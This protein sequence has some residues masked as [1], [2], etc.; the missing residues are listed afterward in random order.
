MEMELNGAG[1][2]YYALIQAVYKGYY[3]SDLSVIY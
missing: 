3:R 1:A 2:S